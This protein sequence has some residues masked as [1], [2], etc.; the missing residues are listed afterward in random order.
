MAMLLWKIWQ[1]G[2]PNVFE[3]K[4]TTPDR[5]WSCSQHFSKAEQKNTLDQAASNPLA[6]GKP[7]NGAPIRDGLILNL[8]DWGIP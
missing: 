5:P 6:S 2:S 7:L 4:E 3:S 8:S 1:A